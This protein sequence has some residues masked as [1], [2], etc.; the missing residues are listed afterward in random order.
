MKA[1]GPGGTLAIGPFSLFPFRVPTIGNG[2]DGDDGEEARM[3]D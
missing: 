3:M 2:Y 1:Q